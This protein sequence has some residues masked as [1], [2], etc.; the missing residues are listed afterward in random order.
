MLNC[1]RCLTPLLHDSSSD[2]EFDKAEK[3]FD[4]PVEHI[5]KVGVN[6]PTTLCMD[7]FDEHYLTFKDDYIRLE[8]L[9][10]LFNMVKSAKKVDEELAIKLGTHE[11]GLNCKIARWV[12][13]GKD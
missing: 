4:N 6:Y 2:E 12:K 10:Y 7:C 13:K 9:C 5:S 8:E 3:S 11:V 1:R